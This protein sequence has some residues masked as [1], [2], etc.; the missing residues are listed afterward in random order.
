VDD[1]YKPNSEKKLN[2]VE[3]LHSLEINFV[4]LFRRQ[5]RDGGAFRSSDRS[6]RS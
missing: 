4:E 3:D 5:G 1:E 6:P 2:T